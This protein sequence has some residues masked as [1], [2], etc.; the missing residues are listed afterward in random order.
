MAAKGALLELLENRHVSDAEPFMEALECVRK[1]KLDVDYLTR[2]AKAHFH[3]ETFQSAE[4]SVAESLQAIVDL[5]RRP[6]PADEMEQ[7]TDEMSREEDAMTSNLGETGKINGPSESGEIGIV[8]NISW[9]KHLGLCTDV[10]NE[11]L[12]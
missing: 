2:I 7:T 1:Y 4:S 5:S 8:R 3:V 11:Q 9:C 12:N 6:I 10:G